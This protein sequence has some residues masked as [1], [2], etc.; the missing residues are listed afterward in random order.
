MFRNKTILITGGTGSWGRKLAEALLEEH[1]KELRILSRNEYA[2]VLMKRELHQDP[3]LRFVIGD[4]RDY[5]AVEEACHKVDYLFHLAALKHVDICEEQPS[6]A[7]KTNVLG[8]ENIIR[9]SIKQRVKKVI[10]VSTDKAVDPMNTYGLT[11]ALGEKLMIRANLLTDRTRFVCVRGGNVL[12]TSGSV[13]PLFLDQI[14]KGKEVTITHHEMTRFFL[15][16]TEAIRLLVIVAKESVGG[17]TFVMKMKACRIVDLAKV[18]MKLSGG[19]SLPFQEIGMRPGERLDELLISKN[20][21]PYTRQ[22]SEQYYMI[23]PSSSVYGKYERYAHLNKVAF[24]EYHSNTE[25]MDEEA[26]A[27]LLRE[28]GYKWEIV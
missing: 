19:K 18:L 1:P 5:E 15:T 11:K 9:A 3:R 16:I 27:E 13:V 23:L 4:I 8:T 17:E 26:I 7:L 21:V 10:N 28:G 2:Q 22:F 14:R 20:E 24:E 25:L 12:G 6:E